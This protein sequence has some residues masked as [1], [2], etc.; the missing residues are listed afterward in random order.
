MSQKYDDRTSLLHLLICSY[1]LLKP[2]YQLTH[3]IFS[4]L[5]WS[6]GSVCFH[7]YS[8]WGI[9][10]GLISDKSRKRLVSLLNRHTISHLFGWSLLI[11]C[12][13][14]PRSVAQYY[15]V[16]YSNPRI[17]RGVAAH[18]YK[19]ELCTVKNESRFKIAG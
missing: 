8:Q 16:K 2:E 6:P 19:F 9:G 3:S 4:I 14:S 7:F 5:S 10:L 18:F 12:R 13:N 17:P 15:G 11:T 1:V